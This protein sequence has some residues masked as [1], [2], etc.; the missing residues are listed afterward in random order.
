VLPIVWSFVKPH[1]SLNTWLARIFVDILS[2]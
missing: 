2:P 1:L